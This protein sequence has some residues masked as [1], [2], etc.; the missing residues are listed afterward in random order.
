MFA[1]CLTYHSIFSSFDK[2]SFANFKIN[3]SNYTI[4]SFPTILFI[5]RS[6]NSFAFH[7]FKYFDTSISFKVNLDLNNVTSDTN[8]VSPAIN[9]VTSE[10]NNVLSDTNNVTSDINN[11]TSDTNNITS[12]TNNV[13]SD[14]NNVTSDT[15]NVTSDIYNVH[16]DMNNVTSHSN[17]EY[18]ENVYKNYMKNINELNCP[19]SKQN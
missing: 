8:N 14:K 16:S 19:N 12:E 13:A 18:S 6:P 11:V 1:S 2:I 5:N 10:T 7:H 9:N 4:F 15:N 17:N 3:Y